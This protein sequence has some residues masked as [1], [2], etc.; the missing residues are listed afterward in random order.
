MSRYDWN[1]AATGLA[2]FVQKFRSLVQR[3]VVPLQ[4]EKEAMEREIDEHAVLF[5]IFGTDQ[6]GPEHLE[7]IRH[8]VHEDPALRELGFGV[9]GDGATWAMLIGAEQTHFRTAAGR[10]CRRELLK[11]SLEDAVQRAGRLEMHV[12]HTDNY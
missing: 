4:I 1:K 2:S 12:E 8:H 6:G 5:G 11:I 3:G 7:V 10:A 9:S